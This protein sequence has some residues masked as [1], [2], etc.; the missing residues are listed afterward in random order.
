[1]LK[2]NKI[3]FF[4]YFSLYMQHNVI[5]PTIEQPLD[6]ITEEIL[7]TSEPALDECFN[8]SDDFIMPII[9]TKLVI[10]KKTRYMHLQNRCLDYCVILFIHYLQFKERWHTFFG[11]LHKKFYKIMRYFRYCF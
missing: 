10:P 4:F 9:E 6:K 5:K 2:T 8:E 7:S 1:M 3:I 11:R